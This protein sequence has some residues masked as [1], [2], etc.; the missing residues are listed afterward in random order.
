MSE[1][2]SEEEMA[3]GAGL[4]DRSAADW[5][6][7]KH[8]S[9][10]WSAEDQTAFDSWLAKSDAHLLS[11]WRL[12]EMWGRSRRLQ[13]LRTPMRQSATTRPRR[14]KLYIAGLAGV[15]AIG[16]LLGLLGTQAVQGRSAKTYSTPIGGHLSLALSDGSKIELNTDSVLKVSSSPAHRFATLEKGEALFEIVHDRAHPFV[17]TSMGQRI[18]DLGTKF[19]IRNEGNYIRVA[20]I[21]GSARVES[22]HE[23]GLSRAT[24]LRPGDIAIAS[25]TSL[26]VSKKTMSEIKRDLAWRNG[27]L[28]FDNT[29]LADAAAELN[30]YNTTKVLISDPTVARLSIGGTFRQND[31]A[32]LLNSAKQVFGLTVRRR[33]HDFEISR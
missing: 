32:A 24:D 15:T 33:G 14:A 23:N 22:A 9:P 21:E 2:E 26:T 16:S 1:R 18:I 12:E 30:R 3:T 8:L 31:F 27:V 13:A 20:L 29:S 11:Y 28:V 17:V 6:L 10:S 5:L 4:I 19:S 25:P 7:A